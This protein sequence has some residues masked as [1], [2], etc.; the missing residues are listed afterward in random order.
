[1]EKEIVSIAKG[2]TKLGKIGNTSLSPIISCPSGV[3]CAKKGKC[4]ALQ[5]YIQY[6]YTKL[7]WDRNLRIYLQNSEVYFEQINVYLQHSMPKFFRWLVSGDIV[8]KNYFQGMMSLAY[9]NPQT[10]FLSFT[11]NYSVLAGIHRNNLP[12][13]LNIIVSAWP[14]YPMPKYI[15]KL[16]YR[17]A[18]VSDGTETRIPKINKLCSG[19]CDTCFDCWD[20]K[21]II[22]VVLPL[23]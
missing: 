6:P 22:D 21:K 14:K 19:H 5:S 10:C 8:N 13:N 9:K 3:P 12:N 18:W 23:H 2:N 11:K 1:M 16:G 4:Y 15:K 7:A 17:I 20:S